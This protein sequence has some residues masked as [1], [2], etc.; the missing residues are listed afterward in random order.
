MSS[1]KVLPTLP[2]W[3]GPPMSYPAIVF[4]AT[5]YNRK[6]KRIDYVLRSTF[7]SADEYQQH[8]SHTNDLMYSCENSW[9]PPRCPPEI[10]ENLVQFDEDKS[11]YKV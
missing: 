7:Y 5:G 3:C 9:R 2:A 8:V 4:D 6:G 11:F 10:P 1:G